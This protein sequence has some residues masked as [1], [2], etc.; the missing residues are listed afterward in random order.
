MKSIKDLGPNEVIHCQ[1]EEEASAIVQLIIDNGGEWSNTR[2]HVY[3]DKTCYYPKGDS[4]ESVVYFQKHNYTIHPAA[5]FI[6]KEKQ[7]KNNMINQI[8]SSLP[9]N[10]NQVTIDIPLGFEIDQDNSDLLKGVVKFKPIKKGLPTKWEDLEN[11]LGYY[12][13]SDCSIQEVTFNPGQ[14]AKEDRNVWPTKELAEA[15]LALCQLIRLRD[16]YNDGWQDSSSGNV[17]KYS[18][19]VY[20]EEITISWHSFTQKV[21]SF[22]D[23]ETADLFLENFKDLILQAKPLL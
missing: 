4:Y 12:V 6:Y 8:D 17:E 15:S 23:M 9:M 14:A 7:N 22:K 20:K 11:V 5:D 16:I 13:E 1:T 21:L 18:I 19:H 3:S 10:I 2:Y